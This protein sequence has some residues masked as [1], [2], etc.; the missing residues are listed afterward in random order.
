MTLDGYTVTDVSPWEDASGSKGITCA[1]A[2]CSA[3]TRFDGKSGWYELVVQYFDQNNGVSH[4]EARVN[5]E[6]LGTWVADDWAP[7]RKPDSNSSTRHVFSDIP[8]RPGDEI[9]I[10]GTPDAGERAPLDYIEMRPTR[11]N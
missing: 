1:G 9:R 2:N 11:L 4:F 6:S 7:T 8:L 3:T 10:I 5:G